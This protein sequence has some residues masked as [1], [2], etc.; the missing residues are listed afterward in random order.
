MPTRCSWYLF[1]ELYSGVLA[2]LVYFSLCQNLCVLPGSKQ[3][4]L[5]SLSAAAEV[6]RGEHSSSLI[7][8]SAEGQLSSGLFLALFGF[9][10]LF[11]FDTTDYPTA[12]EVKLQV[13]SG[14]SGVSRVLQGLLLTAVRGFICRCE[15][16]LCV[17]K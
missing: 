3:K 11:C 6:W 4:L 8:W 12:H 1:G 13:S 7:Y 5:P 17:K 10:F 16:L 9:F 14:N 15:G 2:G